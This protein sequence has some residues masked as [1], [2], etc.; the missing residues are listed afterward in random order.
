MLK[1]KISALEAAVSQL[2]DICLDYRIHKSRSGPRDVVEEQTLITKSQAAVRS[3]VG[4]SSTYY[5][6]VESILRGDDPTDHF[7]VDKLPKLIGVVQALRDNIQAGYLISVQE[8]IHANLFADYL[9]MADHLNGE[10]YKDAAAVTTGST[11]EAHLR[12]LCAKHGVD[13]ERS[14][15]KGTAPKKADQL[16]A[17]LAKAGAYAKLDQKNVTAWL[18]LRNKAAHGEYDAYSSEQVA[19]LIA[20]VREFI[21]RLPA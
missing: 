5:A 11:L 9:E 20:G 19:L 17:D 8:L 10:G 7:N 6:Q 12:Q 13:I 2:G 15:A 3:I 4:S 21:G 14:T 1:T 18:D 16:N